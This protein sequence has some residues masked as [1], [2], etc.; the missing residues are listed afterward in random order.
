MFL[1]GNVCQG[2]GMQ[3]QTTARRLGRE[4]GNR[5]PVDDEERERAGDT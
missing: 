2:V 3:R 4:A 1:N 5:G